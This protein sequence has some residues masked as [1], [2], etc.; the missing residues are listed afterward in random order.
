MVGTKV[1]LAELGDAVAG[2]ARY[3]QVVERL[4]KIIRVHGPDAYKS[5]LCMKTRNEF[6]DGYQYSVTGKLQAA[7]D[8]D[9]QL[10]ILQKVA[11]KA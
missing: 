9:A 11:C 5:K 7:L 10:D 8:L 6:V 4:N 3:D 1:T 2:L